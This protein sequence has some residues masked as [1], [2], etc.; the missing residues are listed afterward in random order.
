[1]LLADSQRIVLAAIQK[2]LLDDFRIVG[3]VLD[4]TALIESALQL[5]PDVI[6]TDIL[7]R[8]LDAEVLSGKFSVSGVQPRSLS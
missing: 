4:G 1:M 3:A 2:L 5:Q 7:S 8:F 6:V